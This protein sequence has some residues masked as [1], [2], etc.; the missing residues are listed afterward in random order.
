MSLLSAPAE[1]AG[2]TYHEASQVLHP[3]QDGLSLRETL[4]CRPVRP[5]A[6]VKA[7]GDMNPPFTPVRPGNPRFLCRAA[8]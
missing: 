2:G 3:E 7:P 4:G 6:A 5:A 8:A 1:E